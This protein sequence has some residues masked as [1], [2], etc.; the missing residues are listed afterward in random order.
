MIEN[1][2]GLLPAEI[3]ILP[4]GLAAFLLLSLKLCDQC[5]LLE[6]VRRA[7]P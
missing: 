4:Q 5:S 1:G 7:G 3:G 2:A 6:S